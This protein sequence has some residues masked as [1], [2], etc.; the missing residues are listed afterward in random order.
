M[1]ENSGQDTQ[2][3]KPSDT[4]TLDNSTTL[5]DTQTSEQSDVTEE[6]PAAQNTEPAKQLPRTA[7]EL[8][9][10]LLAGLAGLSLR[11]LL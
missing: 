4:S 7:G 9:V 10:L 3:E 2:R 11:K 5:S 8:P 1:A 6:A